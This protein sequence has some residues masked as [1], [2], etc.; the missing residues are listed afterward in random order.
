M[1]Y[2]WGQ[3]KNRCL[4]LLQDTV[5]ENATFTDEDMLDYV[6]AA[7]NDL[8]SHTAKRETFETVLDTTTNKVV[9]PDNFLDPGPVAV[10]LQ[11][12]DWQLL[13]PMTEKPSDTLPS[14]M[15]FSLSLNAYYEWPEGVFNLLYM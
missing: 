5:R 14:P 15:A 13:V 3:L 6:N 11:G 4:R 2:R 9:M 12:L 7:L 1:A 10:Q 8:A